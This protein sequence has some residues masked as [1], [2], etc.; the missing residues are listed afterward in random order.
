MLRVAVSPDLITASKSS[1]TALSGTYFMRG[2]GRPTDTRLCSNMAEIA[3][4][5][6]VISPEASMAIMPSE[7]PLSMCF[8]RLRSTISRYMLRDS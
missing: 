1:H 6:C 5:M 3:G 2:S 8:R 7:R 4:F